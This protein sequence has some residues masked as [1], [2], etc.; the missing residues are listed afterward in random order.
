[1]LPA[2]VLVID[3][4]VS[5]WQNIQP[6]EAAQRF[7]TDMANLL[8]RGRHAKIH[9]VIGTQDP[10]KAN[11]NT[12]LSNITA[13]AA[14]RCHSN[15]DS[16]TI[17]GQSGAEYL[18]GRGS[19]L[20]TSTDCPT[21]KR[22]YGSYVSHDEVKQLVSYVKN[23]SHDLSNKFIIPEYDPAEA[24]ADHVQSLLGEMVVDDTANKELA[25][26]IMW[27]LSL[28]KVS[29]S[30]LKEHYEMG[31]RADDIMD[32]LFDMG[33]ISEKNAKQP[34][35][36]LPTSIDNLSPEV[37]KLLSKYGYTEDNITA[38]IAKRTACY[39]ENKEVHHEYSEQ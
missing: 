11:L 26:I 32:K 28:K 24:A 5:L 38:I 23:S 10:T 35:N 31:N 19:M 25:G 9:I 14:F 15:Q 16:R 27:V 37:L 21:P 13:R 4:A 29:A 6:K 3:E 18:E 8:R 36:V 39:A 2:I 30:K 12:A 33:I 20:Y 34:R 17:L 7:S 1:M 22:I